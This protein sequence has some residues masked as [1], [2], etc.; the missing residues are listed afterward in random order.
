MSQD[1]HEF[2]TPFTILAL[3]R[4]SPVGSGQPR[5]VLVDVD[6]GPA[7]LDAALAEVAPRFDVAVPQTMIP[8]GWLT[9]TPR[10]LSGLTRQ[11]LA[12]SVEY[13]AMLEQAAD[14]LDQAAAQG[15]PLEEASREALERW[16]ELPRDLLSLDAAA[17]VA[18]AQASSSALDAI[19]DM[20][21]VGGAA[22][23]SNIVPESIGGGGA[24]PGDALRYRAGQLAGMVF[25]DQG[26]SRLSAAWQGAGLVAS[27]GGEA[28]R[29][30]LVP[31]ALEQAEDLRA[32]LDAVADV[33]D[34][35]PD[36]LVLD[37]PLDRSPGA[38]QAMARAAELGEEFQ[39]PAVVWADVTFLGIKAWDKL[40]TLPYLPNHLEDASYAKWRSLAAKP[41]GEWLCLT[42]VPF[43][44]PAAD[45]VDPAMLSPV[46]G[47]AALA[48]KSAAL[49]GWPSRLTD[50]GRVRLEGL[51]RL[52]GDDDS[53]GSGAATR[54]VL[55]EDRLAQFQEAGL[56]PIAGLA[57]KDQVILPGFVNLAG[58]SLAFRLFVSR[59]LGVLLNLH[60]EKGPALGQGDVGEN[61]RLALVQ[62]L[63]RA[64]SPPPKDLTVEAAEDQGNGLVLTLGMTPPTQA[65]PVAGEFSF[66]FTW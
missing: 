63:E 53:L 3:A 29:L 13:L 65:M 1:A 14:L 5:P 50:H 28:V 62:A 35:R 24:G 10:T 45:D 18:P 39:A 61:V 32:A 30:V 42:C 21:D 22:T 12:E 19:L 57:G 31:A 23:E 17:P 34:A 20:V 7:A 41:E 33:L 37:H 6:K 36:M 55:G 40:P 58:D 26:F 56:S 47:V 49:N 38:Y 64:G 66:S 60:A 52:K 25:E 16:P 9:V 15:R 2:G 51:G 59:F 11:G 54:I 27:Q 44:G 8:S 46:W 43:M 48:A 4:F